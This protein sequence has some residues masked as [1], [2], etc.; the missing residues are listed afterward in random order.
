MSELLG[1]DAGSL[2]SAL[3][4]G[5]AR[6]LAVVDRFVGRL[7]NGGAALAITSTESRRRSRKTKANRVLFNP[8]ARHRQRF[9]RMLR[10]S[11]HTNPARLSTVGEIGA[12]PQEMV[13]V[14]M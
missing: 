4:V 6:E 7:A 9:S 13:V 11:A 3:L 10:G 12:P 5:R 1:E 2:A 14:L 8:H